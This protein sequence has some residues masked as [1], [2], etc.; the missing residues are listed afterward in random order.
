MGVDGGGTHTR[1]RIADLKGRVLGYAEGPSSAVSA[2]GLATAQHVLMRTIDH[3]RQNAGLPDL[4][5]LGAICFGLSGADRPDER[6]PLLQWAKQVFAQTSSTI[7]ISIV[8]DCE[9]VLEAGSNVGWGI[10]LIAGTGSIAFGK[11]PSGAR[12]RAGGWGYLLGDEGSAYDLSRQALRVAVRAADGRGPSTQLLP[13]ILARWELKQPMDLVSWVYRHNRAPVEGAKPTPMLPG[14]LATLATLVA[15]EAAK[16]DL[17]AQTLI[18]QAGQ[19]LADTVL[20]V[21]R[22]LEWGESTIP[23]AL[24]GGLLLGLAQLRE[25]LAEILAQSPYPF[26][27]PVL[28]AEPVVGAIKVAQRLAHGNA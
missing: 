8:N 5:P 9:I 25:R 14:Q 28:V 10:A 7:Q 20:A 19:D 18:R 11:S 4:S 22:R 27:P 21:A 12:V 23:L 24:A 6:E 2:N 3:A 15:E 1:V 26:A 13:A 17:V 16:G